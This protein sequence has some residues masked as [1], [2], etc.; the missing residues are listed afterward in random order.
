MLERL[1]KYLCSRLFIGLSQYY[2]TISCPLH[3][4]ILHCVNQHVI[5]HAYLTHFLSNISFMELKGK[6]EITKLMS[7]LTDCIG[8]LSLVSFTTNQNLETARFTGKKQAVSAVI[9]IINSIE[10]LWLP[11]FCFIK[12][13]ANRKYPS[14]YDFPKHIC[15][16]LVREIMPFIISIFGTFS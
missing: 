9:Q 3:F 4:S 6:V 16:Y 1:T 2:F 15:D 13:I 10:T 8:N 5:L 12:W 11:Y 14:I 7:C